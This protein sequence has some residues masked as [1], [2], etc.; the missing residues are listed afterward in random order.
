[1]KFDATPRCPKCGADTKAMTTGKGFRCINGKVRK[2]GA[3]WI[4]EGCDGVVWAKR[5]AKTEIERPAGFAV[6][7]RRTEEQTAIFRWLETAPGNVKSRFLTI[8][9]GPGCGKTTTLAGGAEAIIKRFGSFQTW[10]F[11]CFNVNAKET[12]LA[13]LPPSVGN[14]QTLN[15]YFGQAQ[16][17][18]YKSYD[19][20]KLYKIW[21]TLQEGVSRQEPPRFNG[22]S[23]MIER[24]RDLLL[25]NPEEASPEWLSLM[26]ATVERFGG[27]AKAFS[28]NA[29]TIKEFLP[30]I[31]TRAASIGGTIDISEQV[32]K[33]AY[34]AIKRIGWTMPEE[35]TVRTAA[36]SDAHVRHFAQLV[37]AIQLPAMNL[38]VDEAQDMSLPILAA[39]LATTWKGKELVVIGD[40]REGTPDAPNYQA[41]QG[42]YGWRGAGGGM[43]AIAE[44]VWKELTGEQADTLPLNS[45][46]RCSPA[47]VEAIKP[48]N[49][50]LKSART[51]SKPGGAYVTDSATAFQ[52]FLSI[53]EG[54]TALWVARRNAPLG[55]VL[56]S[57]ILERKQ[58]CLRGNKDLPAAVERILGGVAKKSGDKWIT[59][60]ADAM[61]KLEEEINAMK[62]EEANGES[63]DS[64]EGFV[65]ALGRGILADATLLPLANVDGPATCGALLSF[66]AYYND[67]SAPRTISTVYRCKG[68]EADL[69]VVDDCE[70]FNKPW[71]NDEWE[72]DAVRHVAA[73][74]AKDWLLLTG[75]IERVKAGSIDPECLL[76]SVAEMS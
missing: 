4:T 20:S 46:F 34:D 49:K 74:R 19:S 48:L 59:P 69:V 23:P 70:H 14:I 61:D 36:W 47:I 2:V 71:N 38:I 44:R 37:K 39:V 8:N 28:K 27:L 60:L 12:L 3:K 68:D 32:A 15:A 55:P 62:E 51:D 72:L 67:R 9:A 6:I 53:P 40:D 64:V 43:F 56:L 66:V 1:M 7:K 42:I 73:S 21:Q 52:A 33:P 22:I 26:L 18:Q 29:D 31:F 54:K 13:K 17:Y 76:N 45:S 10:A 24:M 58:V 65:L 50:V 63:A 75:P 57:T 16:G 30:L 35:L 5:T 25:F 11:L 41:G